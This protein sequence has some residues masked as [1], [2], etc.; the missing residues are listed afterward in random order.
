MQQ[1]LGL[2][3]RPVIVGDLVALSSPYGDNTRE[4]QAVAT[5]ALPRHTKS[6]H[7]TYGTAKKAQTQR[8]TKDLTQKVQ[9]CPIQHECKSWRNPPYILVP[10]LGNAELL[11]PECL[12]PQLHSFQQ[13]PFTV[14]NRKNTDKTPTKFMNNICEVWFASDRLGLFSSSRFTVPSRR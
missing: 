9:T 7:S 4:E 10:G 2:R 3:D 1:E 8:E 14:T 12:S 11:G 6:M 13:A 5:F